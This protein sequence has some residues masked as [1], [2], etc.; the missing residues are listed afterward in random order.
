M[1]EDRLIIV[2]KPVS[3]IDLPNLAKVVDANLEVPLL[4][5]PVCFASR[6]LAAN[7]FTESETKDHILDDVVVTDQPG[8]EGFKTKHYALAS[9]IKYLSTGLTPPGVCFTFR[10]G[11]KS[12][13]FYAVADYLSGLV[14]GGEITLDEALDELLRAVRETFMI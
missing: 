1:N 5:G 9:A 13:S 4:G 7:G 2:S 10:D 14:I 3:R 6:Y 12:S 11:R 8:T